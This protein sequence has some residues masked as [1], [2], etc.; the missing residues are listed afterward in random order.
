MVP[1]GKKYWSKLVDSNGTYRRHLFAEE[2]KKLEGS[3]NLVSR[4]AK[5]VKGYVCLNI[6]LNEFNVVLW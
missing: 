3:G 1:A 6:L 2:N 5:S 4:H